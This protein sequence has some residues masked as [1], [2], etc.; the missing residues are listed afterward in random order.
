LIW[1]TDPGTAFSI[2][3]GMALLSALWIL[4]RWPSL[5]S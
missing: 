3:G 5:N 1:S 2:T 4:I